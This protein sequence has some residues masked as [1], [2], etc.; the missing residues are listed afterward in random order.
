MIKLPRLLDKQLNTVATLHPSRLSAT[1]KI[2]PAS[3]AT[4]GLPFGEPAVAV[5]DFVEIFDADGSKGIY[6]VAAINGGN[7]E[8]QTISLTHGIVTLEDDTLPEDMALEGNIR[9]MLQAVLDQQ[10]ETW[11]QLGTV[12]APEDESYKVQGGNVIAL[13]A[14]INIAALAPEYHLAYDQTTRPW[15]LHFLRRERVASC[16]CRLLRNISSLNVSFSD[17]DM[18]T[19]VTSKLLPDG[20]MDADTI[21]RWGLI[22]RELDT[23]KD[24]T[25]AEAV[26]LAEKVL[27]QRKNPTASIEI[28]AVDLAGATGEDLDRLT[29][30][31]VCR[32]ALPDW[33][34]AYVHQIVSVYWA[35]LLHKPSQKQITLST[36]QKRAENALAQAVK[37]NRQASK[38]WKHITETENSVK[39]Q[40]QQIELLGEEISLR[41]T[42]NEVE[43]AKLLISEVRIDLNAAMAAI[44]LKADRTEYDELEK[45]VSSAEIKV[46][47]ANAAITLKADRTVTD[48]LGTRVSAAEIAI[49]GVNSTIA[50]KADKIDLLGYV[51]ATQLE[52]NYAKISALD[53]ISAQVTNL[54]SGLVTASVLRSSLFTGDQ[55]NFTYLTGTTFNLANELVLKRNI[56]MGTI[57]SVG[58][59]LSTGELDLDHSHEVTVGAD[60]K[61]TMGRATSEGST[62]NLADT[63]FYKD[64]VSAKYT[65]GY[66]LGF[67]NAENAYKPTSITRTGYSTINKTV[68]VKASNAYQDL[69]T[70]KVIDASEIYDAGYSA[71]WAAA[72]AA[73]VRDGYN[74]N[75]PSAAV[76]ESERLFQITA[77]GSLNNIQNTAANYFSVN[78]YA[79][80]YVNGTMVN[81][82]LLTKANGINVGQ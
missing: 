39:I 28:D 61:L 43:G 50:L 25:P 79:Y 31:R 52:T 80:A 70:N 48:E 16:E 22:S 57:T 23:D 53:A 41:A 13:Q 18:C 64:S 78:G 33:G 68:T 76:G 9:Q 14:I 62:F 8:R 59:A 81:S 77:G 37:A 67:G 34:V 17:A 29:L 35:D 44:L 7:V 65:E 56:S 63:Q 10:G 19:R 69:L 4:M 15:T 46:D 30:G 3:T 12:E 27:E 47:G 6:R 26:K 82:H 1:D 51:T 71:G 20:R 24:T 45:R 75:G 21:N 54:T 40:A 32:V 60:G 58:K 66:N 5:R 11:W 42:K 38:G 36:R 2:E 49:D 72:K 55:A 73:I 74:I